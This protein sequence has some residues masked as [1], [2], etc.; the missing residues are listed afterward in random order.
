MD[1]EMI[2]W[3]KSFVKGVP[4][5]DFT[6]P[7]DTMVKVGAAPVGGNFLKDLHTLKN[8]KKLLWK[9][10]SVTNLLSRDAW[11]NAGEVGIIE[12]AR[13][14]MAEM[15]DAHE[16]DIS[17]AQQKDLRAWIADTLD[18]EGITGDD[19][20]RIMDKTY[21]EYHQSGS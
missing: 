13:N 1:N 20:K 21:Y 6:I 14:Q 12:R 18:R 10:T 3:V 16:P 15:L 11:L 19:A 7:M 9:Q 4:V 2:S 17:D 5:D 8:Y